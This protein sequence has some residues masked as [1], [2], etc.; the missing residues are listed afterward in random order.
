MRFWMKVIY[1][2]RWNGQFAIQNNASF[3]IRSHVL[4]R[5]YNVNKT[6]YKKEKHKT[7]REVRAKK[8]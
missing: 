6:C 5:M 1:I 8:W 3:Q 2:L 7:A 4:N